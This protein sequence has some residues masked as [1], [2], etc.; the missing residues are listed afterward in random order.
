[1]TAITF[2]DDDG[3][4][5]RLFNMYKSIIMLQKPNENEN[6]HTKNSPVHMS[7]TN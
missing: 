2:I 5:Y 1:M 4:T 3:V 6:K 7:E